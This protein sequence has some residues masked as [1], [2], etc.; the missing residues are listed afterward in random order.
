MDRGGIILVAG[1]GE[2]G[3]PIHEIL[4]EK[5]DCVGVDIQ[6]VEVDEP[7]TV[8]HICYPFQ[9]SDFVGTTAVYINRY[10]PALTIIHS[11]VAPGTTR[12]VQEAVGDRLV[13]YSPVR[14]KHARMK[15][16]MLHYK[17]FVAAPY[18]EALEPALAHLTEAGF[19]TATF[20][21][22]ELAELSKLVE[23][24]Y[25]GVLIAW[26]QEMERWAEDYQGAFDDVNAFIEEIEFLPSHIFP[27]EIGG[28]CVMPN[29]AILQTQLQ[30]RFLDA[31]LESNQLKREQLLAATAR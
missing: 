18:P 17:K 12:K 20:R 10:E 28:H 8:L 27:G 16:D 25:F 19:Q 15:A 22:V 21:T 29:I 2:V 11:T 1:M 3:R 23:T 24:T 14:G 6:P 4:S 7:C 26:A 13:A 30:S 31:V 9:V 5:F